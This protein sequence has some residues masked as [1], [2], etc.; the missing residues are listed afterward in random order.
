MMQDLRER[1]PMVEINTARRQASIDGIPLALGDK[2]YCLLQAL[3]HIARERRRPR[4]ESIVELL[5]AFHVS[6]H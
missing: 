4:T 2:E 1:R 3:T 6:N 5:K